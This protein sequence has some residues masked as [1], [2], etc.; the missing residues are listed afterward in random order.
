MKKQKKKAEEIL[1]DTSS[2]SSDYRAVMKN[3]QEVR[4]G[5]VLI[6]LP[7]EI[8]GLMEFIDK[9]KDENFTTALGKK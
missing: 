8:D 4:E 9:L 1:Q 2:T 6:A 3:I 5:L 7:S